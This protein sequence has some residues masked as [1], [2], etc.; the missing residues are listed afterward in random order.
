MTKKVIV[1]NKKVLLDTET[2][3]RL[4]LLYDNKLNF[5]KTVYYHNPFTSK[6]QVFY[7]VYNYLNCF[8]QYI[9]IINKEKLNKLL[10]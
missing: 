4:K 6:D 5:Y 7:I 8:K 9:K 10:N 2:D 3:A 1:N